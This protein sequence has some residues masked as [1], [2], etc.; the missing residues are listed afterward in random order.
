MRRPVAILPGCLLGLLLI[1]TVPEISAQRATGFENPYYTTGTEVA[2]ST[3][4]PSVR[5]WYLP[6]R[7][8]SVYDWHQEQYSNYARDSYE[9]YS[10]VF[11]EGS[12]FYDIYGNYIT[13]GWLVYN[14]TEDYPGDNGSVISK[15]P[16]FSSW[17]SNIL[18]SS[19]HTGQYHTS[20]M[21][22]DG[23]RTTLTPLTFSKPRFDGVQ[24]DLTSDKY[25][26]TLL[27]SRVSNTGAIS[28]SD[29]DPGVQ[30]G[31]FTNLWAARG[32]VQV[33]DFAKLGATF[34]NAAHRNSSVP[35]G[36]NSLKG[37][38]SGPMNSDFVRSIVVRIS[39]DSPEDGEGGALLSRWRI[40]ADGVEHTD[41]IIPTV[42]GGVRRRGVIEASGTDV[43]TLTYNIEDFSPSVEDEIDDFR[44]IELIEI[45]LVLANDYKVDITSNKQT[46]NLG[47]P[48]FLPVLR[49]S[50]NVK[51]GSNQAFHKFRY[52]LPSGNRVL[53]FDLVITDVAGFEL[54]GEVVRNFQYRRF[55]NENITR[56]Q[57]LATNKADAFYVTAQQRHYPWTI[58]AE[59]FSIDADY[60]TRAFIPNPQG[61]VFYDNEQRH[62][63]E[64]V[65]DNDDQDELPDWT[66]KYYGS[67]VNTRQGR[68]LLTDSAVFPGIDENN[69][70]I[71]DFNRNFNSQPDYTEPFLRFEV[72]PPEFLY[73]VDMN[74]NGVIDRFEDD[75]V[76]DYPYKRGHR[77]YNLYAGVEVVPQTSVMVGRLDQ[78]LLKT[79]R[80]NQ[81]TY[82]LLTAKKEIP[83]ES[84]SLWLIANPRKVKDDI[85]DDVLVWTE[86]P[87][88]R[89]G[90][91]FTRDLLAARD[92]FVNTT[93]LEVKYDK[94]LP[95][96]AKVKHEFYEQLGSADTGLR[97]QRFLGVI[98]KGEY[99]VSIGRWHILSRW[100]QLYSSRIPASRGV[101]KTRDLTEIFS[102]QANR[103]INRNISFIAGVEF[104]T[105]NNLRRKP[106]P[107]PPGYL[108]DGNTWVLAGQVANSSAYQGYALTTNVGVRW[109][110]HDFDSS[111]SASELFSF[112]TVFVGLGTGR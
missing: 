84:L 18:I 63:F 27:S 55:P 57:A 107:L 1:G 45:G 20:L 104:E 101:L 74:N 85:Q 96:T 83:E 68:D 7:L 70:D 30:A 16:R 4:V 21:V 106:D 64:F 73:G 100:K 78:R 61:D 17:F 33:G 87:G 69:D 31:T 56:H 29:G 32:Q 12:P 48:V 92:A 53:G 72:D 46:N 58:F 10:D 89:G 52:G 5:K 90:P 102:I 43:I 79:A 25:A 82:M 26:V 60:S 34:V 105:F 110:R 71:S 3:L 22:G 95:L 38:L 108:L 35:F 14:W 99:P 94:Y 41:D 39:D 37:T 65:D 15:N 88:S 86:S 111:P 51:D 66:R 62:I 97:D 49:A 42:E 93:Y 75:T 47:S 9:R 24:W 44:E 50:G 103:D 23:I 11:L 6:Q 67:R 109:I 91:Q 54:R 98:T 8:Y 59:A 81:S 76:A 80:D 28:G 19:S 112:I 40:F 77:G 2:P 36:D 13:Q